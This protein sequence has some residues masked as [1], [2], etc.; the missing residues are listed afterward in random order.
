[1]SILI[2]AGLLLVAIYLQLVM[3]EYS[4]VGVARYKGRIIEGVWCCPHW[5]HRHSRNV[6]PFW[7]GDFWTILR[8]KKQHFNGMRFFWGRMSSHDPAGL[9]TRK[10]RAW[11]IAPMYAGLVTV[12]CASMFFIVTWWSLPFW[13]A[14][15]LHVLDFWKDYL[16]GKKT[17]DGKKWRYGP[18]GEPSLEKEA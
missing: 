14:G 9:D 17:T 6:V 8:Y 18:T 11:R 1:M 15:M 2:F 16:W 13:I 7:K 5:Y 3:H 4:H 10:H 12:T